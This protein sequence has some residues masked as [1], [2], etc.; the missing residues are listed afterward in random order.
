V[1]SFEPNPWGLYDVHGNVAEW[2]LDRFWDRHPGGAVVDPY[3][4]ERGR[5]FVLRGGSW[6]DSADRVRSAAREGAPRQSARNSIGFRIVLAPIP[7]D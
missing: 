1:G 5:G 7:E 2:V 4:N 3:N 6:R